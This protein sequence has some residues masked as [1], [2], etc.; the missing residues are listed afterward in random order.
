M[1]FLFF[2]QGNEM[3]PCM[4]DQFRRL[5]MEDGNFV[6]QFGAPRFVFILS[7]DVKLGWILKEMLIFRV[8]KSRRESV[9]TECRC[10]MGGWVVH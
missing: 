8:R 3:R 6:P 1:E 10:H 5:D 2:L 4:D 7:G 9:S